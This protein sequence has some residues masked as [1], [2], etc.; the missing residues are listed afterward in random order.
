MYQEEI[1]YF[2]ECS[3]TNDV[4][5][6]YLKNNRSIEG[7]VIVSEY[8]TAGRGQQ[9]SIWISD[10]SK[11]LLFSII[12]KPCMVPQNQFNINMII[13]TSIHQTLSRLVDSTLLKIKWPND[14]YYKNQKLGGILIE[15]FIKNSRIN[16]SVIGVGINVNQTVFSTIDPI[17]LKNIIGKKINIKDLLKDMLKNLK[18][19]Y[20]TFFLNNHIIKVEYYDC[21]YGYQEIRWFKNMKNNA[22]F[23][24]LILGIDHLGR[25]GV[26]I[27]SKNEYFNFKEIQFCQLY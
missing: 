25:L 19:K 24:G 3:S 14:I 7:T 17:S 15:N 6:T 2:V 22:I 23:E 12:L 8:Q 11:N 10:K 21:L 27:G 9:G 4:A 18:V 13:T 5:I 26:Q 16:N 1:H 20:Q